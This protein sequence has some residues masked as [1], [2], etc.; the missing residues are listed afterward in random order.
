LSIDVDIV[1]QATPAE[2]LAVLEEVSRLSP[3]DGYEHDAER[4]RDLPPKQHFC[5]F[6]PSVIER[7]RAH[8]LLAVLFETEASPHC[9]PVTIADLRNRQI[10]PPWTPLNRLKGANPE[11]F[12]YWQLGQ[13]ILSGGSFR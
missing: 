1:T 7:K 4:D 3:L 2:L 12:H 6:Y 10:E 11:A 5:V 8:I 13:Q 9:E